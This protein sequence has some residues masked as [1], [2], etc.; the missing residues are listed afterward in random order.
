MTDEIDAPT[1]ISTSAETD[2]DKRIDDTDK[3]ST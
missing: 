3:V 2:K 1:M